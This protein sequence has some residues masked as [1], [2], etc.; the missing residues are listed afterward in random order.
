MAVMMVTERPDADEQAW[1]RA[2]RPIALSTGPL[3]TVAT[4]GPPVKLRRNWSPEQIAGWLKRA[5]PDD[6]SYHDVTRDDL[7]QLICSGPRGA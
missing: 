6:E 1:D 2:R 7:P 4:G 5:Y 3:S